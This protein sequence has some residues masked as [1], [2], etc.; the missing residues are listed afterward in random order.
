MQ[1]IF[2]ST[3]DHNLTDMDG[4]ELDCKLLTCLLL[5]LFFSGLFDCGFI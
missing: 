3:N 5:L 4:L 1:C 2:G